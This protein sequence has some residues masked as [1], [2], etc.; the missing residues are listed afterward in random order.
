MNYRITFRRG[1]P[2][3]KVLTNVVAVD[4]YHGHLYFSDG[5]NT[6]CFHVDE[7]EHSENIGK[8]HLLPETKHD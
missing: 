5:E 1:E 4:Y 8:Y 6:F 2:R 3:V 7:I